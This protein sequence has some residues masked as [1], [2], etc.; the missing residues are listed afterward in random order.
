MS[1]DHC[2]QICLRKATGHNSG[3][4]LAFAQMY[5]DESLVDVTLSCG[6]EQIHAH[7]LVLSA[8]SPYFRNIFEKQNNTFH[9]PIVYIDNMDMQDLR[10]IVE[11][12]Y[13]GE[14]YIPEDRLNSLINCANNLQIEGLVHDSG[15][16]EQ[17]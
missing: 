10:S 4:S 2:Q 3:L 16:N 8:C 17:H 1:N 12:M 11:F 13:K 9:Y 5:K 15:L 14:I 6:N 7:K